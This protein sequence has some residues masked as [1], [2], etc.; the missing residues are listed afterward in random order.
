MAK[1]KSLE[2]GK[3]IANNPHIRVSKSLFGLSESI[4]YEPTG[5]RVRLIVIDYE[6]SDG[7]RMARLMA[8]PLDKMARDIIERGVPKG[9]AIGNYRLEA[10]QSADGQF[11]MMQ[12][13]QFG[14]FQYHPVSDAI[15]FEGEA[16]LEAAK[17]L[18]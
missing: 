14:D 3:S 15:V 13:F 10:A 8:Q 5:S 4:V 11:L 1:I 16:A 12:L 2:M 17:L 18:G 7:D 6:Q 9:K